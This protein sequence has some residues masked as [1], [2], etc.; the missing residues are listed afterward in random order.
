MI[1]RKSVSWSYNTSV[2]D[3]RYVS[4]A[5][6]SSGDARFVRICL[7]FLVKKSILIFGGLFLF[8]IWWESDMSFV[9]KLYVL[10]RRKVFRKKEEVAPPE[11]SEKEKI[12]LRTLWRTL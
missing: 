8:M 1:W 7:I 6:A 9:H 10:I 2:A 11:L 4:L 5:L 12:Y 3:D